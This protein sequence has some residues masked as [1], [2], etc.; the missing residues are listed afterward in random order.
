MKVTWAR[1]AIIAAIGLL[2]ALGAAYGA[3]TSIAGE[4]IKTRLRAFGFDNVALT[5]TGL[6]R[7]GLIVEQF[8]ASRGSVTIARA[9]VS[10][11]LSSLRDGRIDT[12]TITRPVLSLTLDRY[13]RT[14]TRLR[15]MSLS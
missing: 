2:L 8:S 3:R 14:N 7:T 4:V 15:D 9:K 6:D 13:A 11:S 12:I 1:T 5:V 10:Y